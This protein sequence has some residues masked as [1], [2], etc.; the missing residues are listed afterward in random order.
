MSHSTRLLYLRP[1]YD[2]TSTIRRK[3]PPKGP[4]L[5]QATKQETLLI[6]NIDKRKAGEGQ[7]KAYVEGPHDTELTL[8]DQGNDIVRCEY[9]PEIEGDYTIFVLFEDAHVP[10]SPLMFLSKRKSILH[11]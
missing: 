10:G 11:L 1:L 9:K 5:S 3:F 8:K 6:F 7:L 2:L 4:D